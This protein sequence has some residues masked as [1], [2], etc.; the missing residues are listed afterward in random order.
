MTS[1][2]DA[3]YQESQ[4]VV[5]KIVDLVFAGDPEAC[6]RA[7]LQCL[8]QA[9]YHLV[10]GMSQAIATAH[11]GSIQSL[12]QASTLPCPVEMIKYV[13]KTSIDEAICRRLCAAV[14][15]QLAEFGEHLR[16]MPDG[17]FQVTA[18]HCLHHE[19]PAVCE[20]N[21]EAEYE[22]QQGH[23]D[24]VLFRNRI[25]AYNPWIVGTFGTQALGSLNI[26]VTPKR[27]RGNLHTD[28]IGGQ[29]TVVVSL[30]GT[31]KV[32]VVTPA[33]T[34]DVSMECK[35][36]HVYAGDLHNLQHVVKEYSPGSISLIF[37]DAEGKPEKRSDGSVLTHP[38][39]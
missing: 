20:F 11:A 39:R 28:A 17:S 1:S 27:F 26:V 37:R 14:K 30:R 33:G 38:I 23:L 19:G 18:L 6:K 31:R 7:S 32:K 22:R 24:F 5:Y 29:L 2:A 25:L 10:R 34:P 4:K 21:H 9:D 35:R 8:E 12:A 15:W 13:Q 16:E 36:G 3:R